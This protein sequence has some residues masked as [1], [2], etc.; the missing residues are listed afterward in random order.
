MSLES[1]SGLV[2]FTG[3]G[4]TTSF[5]FPYAFHDATDLD[6]YLTTTATQIGII[7]SFVSQYDV[8]GTYSP[9]SGENDDFSSGASVVFV[10]APPVGQ[11]V[12]ILR[13]VP[14]TQDT[15]LTQNAG[16]Q[17]SSIEFALDKIVMMI[18]Y[19]F[20]KA[21]RSVRAKD[22]WVDDG[23]FDFT[24]PVEPVANYIL[25]LNSTGTCFEWKVN[26]TFASGFVG[27]GAIPETSFP[28]ANNQ[29]AAA[30]V[31][32]C[33]FGSGVRSFE[34]DAHFYRNTTGVGA[35][36]LAARAKYLAVYKS[37][38]GTWDMTSLGFDGD[39]DATSGAPAGVT[40]SITSAGQVQYTS[41]NITGTAGTSTMSFRANTMGV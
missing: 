24:L 12:I 2:Q 20:Y 15:S 4:S 34:L 38:A 41:S 3:N 28:I 23:T 11:T 31:T 39:A 5:A 33:I 26:S 40:L 22:S 17:A 36:E 29:V 14:D 10:T 13:N 18:Q 25:G 8:V 19:L 32:G 37:T 27:A 1:E 35:T 9:T 21:T 7:Q 6:V 30:N 16:Y